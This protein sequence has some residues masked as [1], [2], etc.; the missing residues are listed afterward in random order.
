MVQAPPS[1]ANRVK[2]NLE[3]YKSLDRNVLKITIE[4]NNPREIVNLNG[5]QVAK[6][7]EVIGI[8]CGGETEGYQ[9]HYGGKSI[10]LS[11]WAKQAVGL[12]RFVS[13]QSKVFS[14]NL[15]ITSVRPA[16]S[17][18]VSVMVVGLPF[19]TPDTLIVEYLECFGAKVSGAPF[20]GVHKN[21][22]WSGQ[23]NG[24]RKFKADF[25]GQV[26]PMGTFHLLVG[27]RIR[28]TYKGNTRHLLIVLEVA[29]LDSVQKGEAG[30]YL[31]QSTC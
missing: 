29:W 20:Y 15:T 13:E 31:S 28:V 24:E 27:A 2:Q 16:I 7:C 22:P 17:R 12:E 5:E 19:N 6:M 23:Y 21:G 26:L 25:S 4:K 14:E 10:T 8:R 1:Y 11:V 18:E 30:V 9:V 3:K